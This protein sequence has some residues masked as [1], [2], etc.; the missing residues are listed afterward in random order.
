MDFKTEEYKNAFF[1]SIIEFNEICGAN[2]SIRVEYDGYIRYVLSIS[3]DYTEKF[4]VNSDGYGALSILH[5]LYE[6]KARKI[7]KNRIGKFVLSQFNWGED[8][9]R[10][11]KDFARNLWKEYLYKDLTT[12]QLYTV[13]KIMHWY[14]D[15]FMEDMRAE[16][17]SH[18][19]TRSENKIL[20]DKKYV[21]SF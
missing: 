2:C 10:F 11:V 13:G 20:N 17:I 6:E 18:W 12:P 9:D 8:L 15:W 1:D 4:H 5:Q 14:E 7:T 19:K 21:N 3:Y 16:L